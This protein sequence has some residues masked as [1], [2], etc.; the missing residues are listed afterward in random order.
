[1]LVEGIRRAGP[2][3]SRESLVKALD[4]MQNFDVGGYNV[5]F[6]PREHNGS[7]FV[8]LTAIGKAGRFAY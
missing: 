8:E 4:S 2:N 5:D 7:K 3:L 6:N 1:V